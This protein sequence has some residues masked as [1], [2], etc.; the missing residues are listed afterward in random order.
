MK[1]FPLPFNHTFPNSELLGIGS[2]GSD[3]TSLHRS[4][5]SESRIQNPEWKPNAL[6]SQAAFQQF[7]YESM[8]ALWRRETRP[9]GLIVSDD[10]MLAGVFSAMLELGIHTPGDLKLVGYKNSAVPVFTP[11]AVTFAEVSTDEIAKALLD[12]IQKQ[13]KGE[14]VSIQR[15][16]PSLRAIPNYFCKTNLKRKTDH[17]KT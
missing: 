8:H 6:R 16:A 13:L 17:D 10:V 1:A 4:E 9:D 5:N 2:Q 12:Q 11:L 3:F 14:P 7:G 15:I